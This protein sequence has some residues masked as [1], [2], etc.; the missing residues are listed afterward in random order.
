MIKVNKYF[1]IWERHFIILCFTLNHFMSYLHVRGCHFQINTFL[2]LVVNAM[3]LLCYDWIFSSCIEL[4]KN[5]KKKNAL[6]FHFPLGLNV[7]THFLHAC[8]SFNMTNHVFSNPQIDV[9]FV[10]LANVPWPFCHTG[11]DVSFSRLG[12]TN[13][14]VKCCI[15]WITL[16]TSQITPWGS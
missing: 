2:H 5:K 6:F 14:T 1:V 8:P 15:L 10:T 3:P 7:S 16:L 11:L 4:N 9:S 12:K 13:F